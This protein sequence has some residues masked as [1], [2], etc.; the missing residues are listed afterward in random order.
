[1]MKTDIQPDPARLQREDL[2]AELDRE[3]AEPV[4]PGL[5]EKQRR[6]REILERGD[7]LLRDSPIGRG[8]W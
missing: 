2:L 3:L 6:T 8:D 4:L 5:E 1:M 7:R